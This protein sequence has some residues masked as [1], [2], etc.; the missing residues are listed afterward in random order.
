MEVA[1]IPHMAHMEA[2]LNLLLIVVSAV[3]E[4][5]VHVVALLILME[6][7]LNLLMEAALNL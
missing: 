2:A 7:A 6:A 5:K 1:L 3:K 4:L